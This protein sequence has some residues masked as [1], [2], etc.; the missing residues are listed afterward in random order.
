MKDNSGYLSYLRYCKVIKILS[1]QQC[2][3]KQLLKI[4]KI[5]QASIYRILKS[6]L[7]NNHIVIIKTKTQD[8][9]GRVPKKYKLKPS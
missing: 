4:T 8:K 5:P 7:V 9:W 3:T 6:L 2:T 1:K